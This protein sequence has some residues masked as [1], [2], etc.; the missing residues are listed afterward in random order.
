MLYYFKQIGSSTVS[1]TNM[2]PGQGYGEIGAYARQSSSQGC[3][4]LWMGCQC[5]AGQVHKHKH[6]RGNLGV[7]GYQTVVFDLERKLK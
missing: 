7:P 1:L 4:S 5:I 3:G 2:H 6:R